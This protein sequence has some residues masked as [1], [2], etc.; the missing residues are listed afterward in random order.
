MP[1]IEAILSATRGGAD[2]I[3]APDRIGSLR[4]GRFADLV[5]VAGD[6]LKDITEMR[7]ITFVMKGGVVYKPAA[8]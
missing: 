7:R 4:A 3:G 5:A 6:P 2:L 8:Q 1:P